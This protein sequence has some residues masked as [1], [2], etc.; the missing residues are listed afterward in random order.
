MS[1][2]LTVRRRSLRPVRSA[3][4]I[5]TASR[6]GEVTCQSVRGEMAMRW[7]EAEWSEGQTR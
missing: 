5:D 3:R 7:L 2:P 6:G 1:E 4:G